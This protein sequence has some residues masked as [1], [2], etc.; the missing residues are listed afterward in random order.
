MSTELML[1]LLA[2][3]LFAGV[4]LPAVWS[5]HGYRRTA[6][7]RTLAMLLKAVRDLYPF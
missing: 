3:L 6:A 5:R 1:F 7:R 4:V 2:L